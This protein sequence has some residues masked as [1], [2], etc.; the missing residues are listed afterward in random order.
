MTKPDIVVFSMQWHHMY[1]D[2]FT[3]LIVNPLRPY[4]NVKHSVWSPTALSEKINA[5]AVILCIPKPDPVWIIRQTARIFWTPMWDN[6]FYWTQFHWNTLPRSLRILAFSDPVEARAKTA[7]LTTLP[8]RFYRNP[9]DFPEASWNERVLLHWNRQGMAT[10]EFLHQL[11]QTLNVDRLLFRSQPDLSVPPKA[12]YPLP[13]RLGRT[14]VESIANRGAA[15]D[16]RHLLRQANILLAPR[17]LEGVGLSFLEALA[18]GCAVLAPNAPTMNEYITHGED[19][20]LFRP[21]HVRSHLPLERKTRRLLEQWSHGR[22]SRPLPQLSLEQDWQALEQAPLS[23]L[24]R[25]AR[26]RQR[27]GFKRWQSQIDDLARFVLE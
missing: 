17:F 12:A 8:L 22:I 3:E 14:R 2:A 24:G 5:H 1:S 25:A 11:C 23:G 26:E 18:S 10:P 9:D 4:A 15:E 21:V 16:Y 6:I 7:G 13:A 20:F 27:A 19:G